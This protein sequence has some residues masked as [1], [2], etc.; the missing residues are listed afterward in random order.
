MVLITTQFKRATG[1]SPKIVLSTPTQAQA[2]DEKKFLERQ[3][4]LVTKAIFGDEKMVEFTGQPAKKDW[5]MLRDICRTE[6]Q[7]QSARVIN[8]T[9]VSEVSREAERLFAIVMDDLLPFL[10]FTDIRLLSAVSSHM[11]T[12]IFNMVRVWD[13]RDPHSMGFCDWEHEVLGAMFLPLAPPRIMVPGRYLM[14][15]GRGQ[16]STTDVFYYPRDLC[17]EWTPAFIE[18]NWP[19]VGGKRMA[20]EAAIHARTGLWNN[21]GLDDEPSSDEFADHRSK[22]ETALNKA[23]SFDESER[24]SQRKYFAQLSHLS[25]MIRGLAQHGSCISHLELSHI[26]YLNVKLTANIVELLPKLEFLT[27]NACELMHLGTLIPLLDYINWIGCRR[28]GEFIQ[29]DFFPKAWFGP[30]KNRQNTRILT[31]GPVELNTRQAV[32]CT[33]IT[34]TMKAAE[35]G[36]DILADDSLL[37]KYLALVPM[38]FGLIHV[39]IRDLKAYVVELQARIP[40]DRTRADRARL[41]ALE[42][43]ILAAFTTG[44]RRQHPAEMIMILMRQQWP[45]SRCGHVYASPCYEC[46]MGARPAHQRVCFPCRI[47]EAIENEGYHHWTAEKRQIAKTLTS[48]TVEP[49]YVA[50]VSGQIIAPILENAFVAGPPATHGVWDQHWSIDLA[51]GVHRALHENEAIWRQAGYEAHVLDAKNRFAEGLG[52]YLDPHYA[53]NR[54]GDEASAEPKQPL[55]PFRERIDR[56]A[57]ESLYAF[58]IQPHRVKREIKECESW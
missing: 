56:K 22:Y 23:Q 43:Q 35:M 30:A 54:A 9:A 26:P 51:S 41:A 16:W 40:E 5:N 57:W 45:C 29:L 58:N 10:N 1:F 12:S 15:N 8:N 24:R 42:L 37:V 7:E 50:P 28:D 19:V 11:R 6:K 46:G 31:W 14:V 2:I 47:T 49:E 36:H 32:M 48:T 4:R 34:A 20:I 25:G 39:F 21:L 55:Q 18:D 44:E 13:L 33:M 3:A 27:I 53:S 52:M 17:P 38:D